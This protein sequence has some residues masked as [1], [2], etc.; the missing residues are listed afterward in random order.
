MS[1]RG[2]KHLAGGLPHALFFDV[3]GVLI[4]SIGIKGDAFVETFSDFPD[5]AR[6]VRAF[7]EAHGGLNRKVKV[8]GILEMLTGS[9]P[10]Q[11][12]VDARV[13]FFS[14]LACERVSMA[15]EIPGARQHLE[16]W[17]GRCSLFAVSATPHDELQVILK[18]RGLN[19]FFEAIS[20]WPHEKS[21]SIRN[22]IALRGYEPSRCVLIGDSAEDD[23]AA[24]RA[25]V[26]FLQYCQSPTIL[27]TGV[28][29]NSW[30]EFNQI[31]PIIVGSRNPINAQGA[32]NK[33]V[34]PS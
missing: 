27:S 16:S 3:D 30:E 21:S 33:H 9:E 22:T 29:I 6:N 10:S 4:D 28:Q 20:G 7:H 19:D 11:S 32:G 23:H 12:D 17:F 26:K 14:G 34:R 25:S 18:R 24:K 1:A 31:I 5:S 8:R 15:P 2:R 13:R